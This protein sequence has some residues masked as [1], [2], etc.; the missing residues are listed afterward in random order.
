LL[1]SFV[2]VFLEYS[3][4]GLWHC[5]SRAAGI[6]ET[7]QAEQSDERDKC[8]HEE[9]VIRSREADYGVEKKG[10]LLDVATSTPK[11]IMRTR[12]TF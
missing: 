9:P 7:I 3:G 12:R 1:P 4:S 10:N 2:T 8:S 11:S 6:V 5:H